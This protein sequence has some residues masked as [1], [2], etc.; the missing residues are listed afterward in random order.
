MHIVKLCFNDFLQIEFQFSA[1][2]L[3][4]T[5]VITIY[6]YIDSGFTE[7]YLW[8]ILFYTEPMEDMLWEGPDYFTTRA[9]W[10]QGHIVEEAK[11]HPREQAKNSWFNTNL[12]CKNKK[13]MEANF[14]NI[15]KYT[16]KQLSHVCESTIHSSVPQKKELKMQR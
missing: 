14:E 8:F 15:K 10:N 13:K 3:G 1:F 9:V 5:M 16:C 12:W 7:I 2:N 4:C 6:R 11:P